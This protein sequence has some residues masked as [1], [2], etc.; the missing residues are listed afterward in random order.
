MDEEAEIPV[1]ALDFDIIRNAC[2]KLIAEEAAP[3][4]SGV[5][6]AE[7]LVREFTGSA[8]IDPEMILS[9]VRQ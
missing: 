7:R 9:I 4:S 8:K 1:S 5:A 3:D 2:Q 6:H